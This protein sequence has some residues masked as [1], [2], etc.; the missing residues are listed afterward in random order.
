M[1][2]LLFHSFVDINKFNPSI[3][4][5]SWHYMMPILHTMKL[6]PS[7]LHSIMQPGGG[8]PG[9]RAA[10]NCSLL[11]LARFLVGLNRGSAISSIHTQLSDSANPGEILKE[12]LFRYP[13]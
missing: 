5:Q 6:T 13:L 11:T 8:R 2:Q 9:P 4:L 12:K 7:H 1:F 10:L 3:M